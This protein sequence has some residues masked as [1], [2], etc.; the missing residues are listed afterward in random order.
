MKVNAENQENQQQPAYP[1]PETESENSLI[2]K[3]L[4][5][6]T[7]NIETRFQKKRD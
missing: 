1:R 2:E 6:R 4:E 3:P 7:E 5:K